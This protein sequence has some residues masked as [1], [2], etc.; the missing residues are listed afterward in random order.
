MEPSSN[1]QH[2]QHNDATTAVAASLPAHSSSVNHPPSH[3]SSVTSSPALNSNSRCYDETSLA[4]CLQ[5][6]EYK[7]VLA[8]SGACQ[9]WRAAAG[10]HDI[11]TQ[12]HSQVQLSI[13]ISTEAEV[14]RVVCT[15]E[16]EL[17]PISPYMSFSSMLT[18]IRSSPLMR[19][20]ARVVVE[21]AHETVPLPSEA[22]MEKRTT[23]ELKIDAN[24]IDAFQ[25]LMRQVLDDVAT[26]DDVNDVSLDA[27][28]LL[29]PAIATHPL[30]TRAKKLTI[31]LPQDW[32]AGADSGA[33][34]QTELESESVSA[35]VQHVSTFTSALASSLSPLL[36]TTLSRYV[37]LAQLHIME[38]EEPYSRN[39]SIQDQQ[40][41]QPIET[42][43]IRQLLR[44]PAPTPTSLPPLHT[45]FT[46]SPSSLPVACPPTSSS[47]SVQAVDDSAFHSLPLLQSFSSSCLTESGRRVILSLLNTPLAN[48]LREIDIKG[49]GITSKQLAEIC[50]GRLSEDA[51]G[52]HTMSGQSKIGTGPGAH[53]AQLEKLYCEMDYESNEDSAVSSE[54]Y[55]RL[56]EEVSSALASLPRLCVIHIE[57]RDKCTT[58]T[59]TVKPLILA[60]QRRQHHQH[61]RAE[62]NS[63]EQMNGNG[64]NGNENADADEKGN[65]NGGGNED[66]GQLFQHLHEVAIQL[67]RPPRTPATSHHTNASSSADS[68]LSTAWLLPS[69]PGDEKFSLPSLTEAAITLTPAGPSAA[70]LSHQLP[71]VEKLTLHMYP[72]DWKAHIEAYVYSELHP[73]LD[74][75]G[76]VWVRKRRFI[77]MDE[78]NTAMR[79]ILQQWIQGESSSSS[80]GSTSD[81]NRLCFAHLTELELS[82]W[83]G[84]YRWQQTQEEAETLPVDSPVS[85]LLPT[86]ISSGT[87]P[88]LRRIHCHRFGDYC[89][90]HKRQRQR[91]RPAA[92]PDPEEPQPHDQRG[93]DR[94]LQLCQRHQDTNTKKT[95]MRKKKNDHTHASD[96]SGNTSRDISIHGMA[97]DPN[98]SD[99]HWTFSV[100]RFSRSTEFPFF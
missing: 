22:W 21:W 71:N 89:F 59:F 57:P 96:H 95:K 99:C 69:V 25:Q 13:T 62:R 23:S 76:P 9:T 43:E 93:A 52:D 48:N 5:W 73:P 24:R 1:D 41:C 19:H 64:M 91:R 50:R 4:L 37:Q 88:A 38:M 74:P 31:D 100:E 77:S 51:D 78:E 33:A 15:L 55:A 42:N 40:Y 10:R 70:I 47:S 81:R 2:Q 61:S 75:N 11:L 68:K 8:A 17:Q 67:L 3:S 66:R 12:L 72:S 36:H 56:M 49:N 84:M 63:S 29:I 53:L 30:L 18:S 85:A 80:D 16:S 87:F 54:S 58:D 6:L 98:E 46:S 28:F 14:D 20:V 45:N 82:G 97:A 32:Q 92:D 35:V 26:L 60:L 94:E 44:T 7:D 90:T 27:R 34:T 83:S 65:A 79:F 86:L 39:K